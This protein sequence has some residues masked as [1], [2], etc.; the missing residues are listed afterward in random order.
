MATIL[1]NA[2]PVFLMSVLNPVLMTVMLLI[3]ARVATLID[4]DLAYLSEPRHAWNTSQMIVGIAGFGFWLVLGFFWI[5]LIVCC[6]ITGSFIG[7]YIQFRNRK[8]TPTAKWTMRSLLFPPGWGQ[9][10]RVWAKHAAHVQILDSMGKPLMNPT[11]KDPYARAHCAFEQMLGYALAHHTE[12]ILIRANAQKASVVLHVDGVGYPQPRIEPGAAAKLI[13][14]LKHIAG[15]DVSERR[16]KLVGSMRLV[17]NEKIQHTINL[18]TFGSLRGM[19]LVIDIKQQSQPTLNLRQLGLLPAQEEQ[20]NAALALENRIVL[21]ATPPGQGQTEILHSLLNRHNPNAQSMIVLEKNDH[22]AREGVDHHRIQPN[23]DESTQIQQVTTLMM[24]KPQ[25]ML[26][27][28]P[29]QAQIARL[30]AG[31]ASAMRVYTGIRRTDSFDA[32]QGW[33]RLI[34]NAHT[35]SEALGVIIAGQLL[36]KLCM[37]CRQP[38]TPQPDALRKLNLSLDRIGHLYRHDGRIHTKHKTVLCNDCLGLGYRGRVGVFEVMVLDEQ[39]RALI[40]NREFDQLRIHLRRKKMLWLQEAAL[41]RVLEGSTSISELTRVL[42]HHADH[43]I[44]ETARVPA[45]RAV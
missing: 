4:D 36:R 10:Q 24:T 16:H 27:E 20:L 42:G 38:Y 6:L 19:E 13:S 8:V 14:Y 44:I 34:G 43:R 25:V 11:K 23:D 7:C 9:A 18:T 5:G 39:A 15:L 28:L 40:T 1:A 2:E 12:R 26:V 21:V 45:S 31:D 29:D 32:L 22:F 30:L 35:A 37:T 33:I 41:S 17:T 3:W